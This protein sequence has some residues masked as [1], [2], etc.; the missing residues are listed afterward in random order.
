MIWPSYKGNKYIN[1][2]HKLYAQHK[3]FKRIEKYKGEKGK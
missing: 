3:F 1:K 2:Q